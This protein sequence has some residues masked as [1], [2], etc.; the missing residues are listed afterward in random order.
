MP[1]ICIGRVFC[2]L[3]DVQ[4]V[5]TQISRYSFLFFIRTR[6]Q[7]KVLFLASRTTWCRCT[8]IK[9]KLSLISRSC[10]RQLISRGVV[11]ILLHVIICAFLQT[12]IEQ[13]EQ[14]SE[15]IP[16]WV[17]WLIGRRVNQTLCSSSNECVNCALCAPLLWKC[18]CFRSCFFSIS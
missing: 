16:E 13:M 3:R 4:I 11:K 14:R 6:W 10:L 12:L 18:L 9:L 7:L 15:K 2:R 5:C 1:C 17:F 8:P